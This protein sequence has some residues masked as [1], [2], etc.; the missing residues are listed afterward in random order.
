MDARPLITAFFTDVMTHGILDRCDEIV[1]LDYVEHAVA[2]FGTVA[3]GVVAGPQHL[4][5]T[6]RWLR[7]QFPDLEMLVEHVVQE[8]DLV[9]VLVRS[10]GTNLG[11]LNGVIPPTGRS[12]DSRQ[13]HWF[14]VEA[15]RLAEHWA[16]REDL[17]TMLQLGVIAR[18]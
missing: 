2:P 17:L 9:A 14:R 3:P 16:T 13:S 5:E 18:P 8:N 11:E 12:F 4:R 15:G 6:A 1:A 7:E 10:R